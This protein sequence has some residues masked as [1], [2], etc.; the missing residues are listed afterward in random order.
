MTQALTKA[1]PSLSKAMPQGLLVPSQKS[2][3]SRVFGWMR[4]RAQV[5]SN[6]LPLLLDVAVVEDAVEAVEP[7]VGPPGQRVGQF[8][9]VVAAEAGDDD[10]RLAGRLAVGADLVEEDVGRV[11]DP[12]AAVAD[13]DAGGDVQPLGEDGDLV[14]LAVAA[15]CLRGP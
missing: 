13:G 12:D 5:K 8:V 2:W 10:L 6:S 11:G 9:R 14:D 3:N 1:L 7:A 4:N 15:R